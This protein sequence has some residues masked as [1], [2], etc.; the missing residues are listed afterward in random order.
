MDDEK[1]VEGPFGYRARAVKRDCS[2]PV[3]AVLWMTNGDAFEIGKRP[4]EITF[5]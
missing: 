4:I 1:T 2:A 3:L 5:H